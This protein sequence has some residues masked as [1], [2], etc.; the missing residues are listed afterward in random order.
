[1][2]HDSVVPPF[3]FVIP[4]Q[5]ITD[6]YNSLSTN[7]VGRQEEWQNMFRFGIIEIDIG[8]GIM[9]EVY[10]DGFGFIDQWNLYLL[11]HDGW[12]TDPCRMF[13]YSS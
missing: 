2:A 1:M 3:I 4:V 11:T 9:R 10:T 8:M 7:F 5:P 13:D 6:Y 12:P